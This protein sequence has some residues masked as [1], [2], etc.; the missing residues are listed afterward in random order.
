M[1]SLAL[2][3]A[4]LVLVSPLR[5]DTPMSAL[6]PAQGYNQKAREVINRC[7]RVEIEYEFLD[8][9]VGPD[10]VPVGTL[11][12]TPREAQF[13]ADAIEVDHPVPKGGSGEWPTLAFRFYNGDKQIAI[14]GSHLSSDTGWIVLLPWKQPYADYVLTPKSAKTLRDWVYKQP[15]LAKKVPH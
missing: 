4:T 12:L 14:A 2:G 3:L 8:F 9:H 7:S 13:L 5:A 11:G 6:T 10:S 1:K 15:V